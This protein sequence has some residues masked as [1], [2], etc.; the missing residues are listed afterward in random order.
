MH[1]FAGSCSDREV[2]M[3]EFLLRPPFVLF[4][5]WRASHSGGR[6]AAHGG[7][8]RPDAEIAAMSELSHA[9]EHAVAAGERL[10]E[11]L[12]QSVENE[13]LANAASICRWELLVLRERMIE[14]SVPNSL[15]AVQ[16]ESTRHVDAAAAAAHML[17]NGYRFH[18][19]DRICQGGEALETQ[20]QELERLRERLKVHMSAVHTEPS[21]PGRAS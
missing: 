11:S 7:S 5:K 4:G 14:T 15:R 9:I 2:A 10:L 18:N 17:G 20:L 21:A 12:R 6:S 3:A 8:A 19:L 13:P 1:T 16:N